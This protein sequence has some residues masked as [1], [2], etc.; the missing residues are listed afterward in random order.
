MRADRQQSAQS[1]T[2]FSRL[3][4]RLF[5]PAGAFRY[6]RHLPFLFTLALARLLLLTLRQQLFPPLLARLGGREEGHGALQRRAADG[7]R[8]VALHAEREARVQVHD[9]RRA[10]GL[11]G[12]ATK[13]DAGGGAFG[14]SGVAGRGR[15]ADFFFCFAAGAMVVV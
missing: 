9:L 6:A 7:A 2:W 4:A 15:R 5:L 3:S 12:S 13:G 8:R 1:W 14:A 10:R 11:L